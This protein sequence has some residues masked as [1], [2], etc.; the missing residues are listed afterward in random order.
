MLMAGVDRAR[1]IRQRRERRENEREE[2][3][4]KERRPWREKERR[5]WREEE[6]KDGEKVLTLCFALLGIV[7]RRGRK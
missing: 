5:Q 3:G 7:G 1:E 6:E 2:T 4:E